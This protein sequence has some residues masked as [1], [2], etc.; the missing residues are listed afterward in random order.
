MA[1]DERGDAVVG[2]F[3]EQLPPRIEVTVEAAG[4]LHQVDDDSELAVRI[5]FH[6][7][8]GYARSAIFHGPLNAVDLFHSTRGAVPP[9]GTKRPLDR[10]V[11]VDDLHQFVIEPAREAPP[12]WT[13]RCAITWILRHAGP[14]TRVRIRHQAILPRSGG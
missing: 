10:V 14:E 13:G 5:D 9:W 11:R 7:H 3:A 12:G 8:E 6:T 1:G 4:A 2:V